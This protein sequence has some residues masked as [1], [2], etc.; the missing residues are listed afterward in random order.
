MVWIL[1]GQID[2]LKSRF[3]GYLEPY[4]SSTD[5]NAPRYSGEAKLSEKER[6][7]VKENLDVILLY[8]RTSLRTSKLVCRRS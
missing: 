7:D 6:E 4:L 3:P 1:D 2:N 8:L 5:T